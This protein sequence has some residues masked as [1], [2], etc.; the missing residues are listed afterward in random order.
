MP[1]TWEPYN[2][3]FKPVASTVDKLKAGVYYLWESAQGT[4]FEPS[5]QFNDPVFDLPGL[6]NE[7]IRTQVDQFW[8]SESTYKENGFVH[9]R[10]ILLYGPPGNGK[11]SII[12]SLIKRLIED[13]GVVVTIGQF[14]IAGPALQKLKKVEPN[15]KLMLLMEDMD[16]LLSGDH[17]IEEPHALSL[18]DG[19]WSVN[20]VVYVATTNY[21]ELLADRFIKRPGRFDLIIGMGNPVAVTRRAYLENILPKVKPEIIEM[22]VAKTEGLSLSYLREIASGFLCLNIPIEESVARLK[23]N[24]A[25]K[26]K[27]KGNGGNVG[28]KIGYDGQL[29]ASIGA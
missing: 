9:K 26:L 23:N 13:D 19:Q 4:I 5:K 7:F 21:P 12:A 24:A 27:S 3:G 6:P 17:K 29:G 2:S 10:G 11:T 16:T 22:I 20:G 8:K 25:S 18:L 1:G 28:F 14:S 15:R